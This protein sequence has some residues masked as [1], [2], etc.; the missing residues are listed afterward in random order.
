MLWMLLALFACDAGVSFDDAPA[1]VVYVPD[2]SSP[3]PEATVPTEP[4][5]YLSENERLAAARARARANQPKLV[6]APQDQREREWEWTFEYKGPTQ[7]QYLDRHT[8]FDEQQAIEREQ[9]LEN[10][11]ELDDEGY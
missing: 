6:M 7:T 1:D 2:G 11:E 9:E 4:E 5:R 10:G 8:S 3:A